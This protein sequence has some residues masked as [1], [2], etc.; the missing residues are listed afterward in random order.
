MVQV[1][2]QPANSL[3]RQPQQQTLNTFV[4]QVTIPTADSAEEA[5]KQWF[6]GDASKGLFQG[7]SRINKSEFK[8][9]YKKYSERNVLAMAFV[10]YQSFES[11]ELAYRGIHQNLF[12]D[13]ERGQKA[14]KRKQIVK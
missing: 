5:W 10:K 1:P 9:E 12:N 6:V 4:R 13:T 2:I 8:L 7:L 11:F 14:Q 3:V